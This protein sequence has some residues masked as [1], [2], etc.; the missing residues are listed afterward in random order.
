MDREM[1]DRIMRAEGFEEGFKQAYEE[2][3]KKAYEES[4]DQVRR[5]SIRKIFNYHVKTGL[6]EA[7]V[8]RDLAEMFHMS[9]GEIEAVLAETAGGMEEDMKIPLKLK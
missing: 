4:R 7:N 9:T 3:F 2:G 1:R 6:S 8:I 5:E